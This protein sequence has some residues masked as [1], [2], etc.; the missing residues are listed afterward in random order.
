[1]GKIIKR[2]AAGSHSYR[3]YDDSWY[4]SVAGK[5]LPLRDDAGNKIKGRENEALAQIAVGKLKLA[6]QTAML[7]AATAHPQTEAKPEPKKGCTIKHVI[8]TYLTYTL[9]ECGPFQ[10]HKVRGVLNSFIGSAGAETLVNDLETGDLLKWINAHDWSGTTT[11]T[12]VATLNAA[13]NHSVNHY[14]KSL[15]L[16]FNGPP[17]SAEVPFA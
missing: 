2:R 14:G 4:S 12:N 7:G 3:N 15:G 17:G 1:M 6:V 8:D 9:K 16:L 11:H 13:I 10:H 5:Y